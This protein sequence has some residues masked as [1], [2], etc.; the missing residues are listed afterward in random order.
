MLIR[1]W[2]LFH[3]NTFP[4]G[5]SV[6]LEEM[7]GLASA[8]RPD[9]LV[10]QEV[11]VWALDE[12]A[13][14]ERHGRRRRR[15]PAAA[16]GADPDH[17]RARTAAD[18]PEPGLLRSAFSGQGNAI[19]LGEGRAGRP[20]RGPDTEPARGSGGSRRT[21][22]GSTSSR[23]WPG[24]RSGGSARCVRLADGHVVANL[25]ATGSAG[26][27]RIPAA[28]LRRAVPSI[29]ALAQDGDTVVIAGDFNAVAAHWLLEG[30]SEPGPGIDHIARSRRRA[31]A[32][33]GLGRRAAPPSG[34]AALGP[35][36]D[37][38]RAVNFNDARAQFPVLDRLAYLNAGT[39]GPLARATVEAMTAQQ[40]SRPRAGPRRAPYI[41]TMLALRKHVRAGLARD[42]RRAGRER[43]AD[44]VDDR[45]LQHR[46][47]PGCACGP[48]TRS[49]PPTPST[50]ACSA[51]SRPRR[52]P[53]ASPRCRAQPPEQ[54]L[55]A[56][57]AEVTPRTRLIA[58]SHVSWQTGNLL[59]IEEL[60]DATGLP[61]LVDGAQSA[62]AIAVEAGRY[63]YY[64]VSGQKWLCGPDATGGA[65]RPRPGGAARRA[66]DLLL[67]GRHDESGAFTPRAG[68]G[69]VRQRLD[70]DAV[71][72]GA[73]GR[74]RHGPALGGSSR[75]RHRRAL[76]GAAR[77]ALRGRH[78]ARPGEARLV[79]A[80]G[81]PRRDAQK[82]FEHGV[83]VRDMPGTPWLR[84]S[85]GWWTSDGDLERLLAS[86]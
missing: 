42:D 35:P 55:E 16:A 67:A 20:A 3:G 83:V 77:R 23:G 21:G 24:G 2:N 19:L 28:E 64:T 79:R 15:R 12:L 36:A 17:G 37:R 71:A 62:G 76:L 27:P 68:R 84:V 86:L 66:A 52:R 65:V 85:C 61:M 75:T 6:H 13:R 59:P 33:H 49:S 46:R 10:L 5:S 80:R 73:R 26:D 78:G 30:Y 54:A 53:C 25:H 39:I 11:P 57:L 72:R 63:D 29:E 56:I 8:D 47:S 45:G 69:P 82:L 4:P 9:V 32:D 41:E 70:A 34:H 74:A 7:V 81:R 31:L 60:Q 44:H 40:L 1:S 51:R 18:R 14:V 48:R 58:L 43:R 50:S 38:D 22:S